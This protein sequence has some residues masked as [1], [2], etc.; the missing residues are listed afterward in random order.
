MG[1]G[2]TGPAKRAYCWSIWALYLAPWD[3]GPCALYMRVLGPFIWECH[4]PLFPKHASGMRGSDLNMEE[5]WVH[6]IVAAAGRPTLSETTLSHF[7]HL[8]LKT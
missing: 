3:L 2:Q 1:Q 8:T 4:G 5:N 7:W 6:T